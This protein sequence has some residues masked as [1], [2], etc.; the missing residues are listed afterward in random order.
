MNDADTQT[1]DSPRIPDE[2]WPA[3]RRSSKE[4]LAAA[5]EFAKEDRRRSWFHVVE[6]LGV[7]GVALTGAAL[8]PY[9]WLRLPAAIFAGLVLVRGFI[10]YHDFMH[11]SFLRGSTVGKWIM[12]AY[13]VYVLTPPNVW[14][15]THNY[16][17]AHTA[18]IVGSHVGSYMMVTTEMWAKMTP[19]ERTAYKAFRH[20]LT[21]FFAYFTVFMWGMCVSSFMRN[22]R[23]NWDSA[24]AVV[25]HVA[26]W[27]LLIVFAGWDMFLFV[28]FVPLFVATMSGAYLF[29]AQHNFPEINVQPRD[30]WEYSRAALES[31]SYMAMNPVL[32]WLTGNIGYHH[33]HHLNPAIPFYRLPEAMAAIPELREPLG[34]TSLSPSDILACFRAKLWDAER[35]EM[36]GYPRG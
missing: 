32:H 34:T 19:M 9:W 10:L 20:P 13:G 16:H 22:P 15:Q 23:K 24:L 14:R 29:Y 30:K 33:V 21:I 26:A 25:L 6:T 5:R 4:L 2:G 36:V 11:L 1:L 35:G 3:G 27:P 12:H 31:S 7:L 28:Y 8:L 18:K 17:H